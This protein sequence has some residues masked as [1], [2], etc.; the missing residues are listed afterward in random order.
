M[1]G[2][3]VNSKTSLETLSGFLAFNRAFWILK[4]G[5]YLKDCCVTIV[6]LWIRQRSPRCARMLPQPGFFAQLDLPEMHYS[7]ARAFEASHRIIIHLGEV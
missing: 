6:Q 7:P 5:L 2:I 3:G 1:W 4:S